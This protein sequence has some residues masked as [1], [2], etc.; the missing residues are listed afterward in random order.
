MNDGYE[1]WIDNM[2][3]NMQIKFNWN[4]SCHCIVVVESVNKFVGYLL[5][6]V[7]FVFTIITSFVFKKSV[8]GARFIEMSE[9]QQQ[10]QC[11]KSIID[12]QSWCIEVK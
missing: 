5:S 6:T 3:F 10:Q 2:I 8:R 1:R 12:E 7:K 4:T 11:I 9:K